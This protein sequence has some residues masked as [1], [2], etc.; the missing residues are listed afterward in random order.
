MKAGVS[1]FDFFDDT[2]PAPAANPTKQTSQ[3]VSGNFVFDGRT[4][5]PDVDFARLKN[6]TQRVLL[7]L[8]DYLK[9]GKDSLEPV[10]GAAYDSR[11]RDLR[12][13]RFG[14]FII[15]EER[16]PTTNGTMSRYWLDAS[17]VTDAKIRAILAWE[18]PDED[19]SEDTCV[20]GLRTSIRQ[21]IKMMGDEQLRSVLEYIG[22]IGE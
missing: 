17:S 1:I 7:R 21:A 18:I 10:G 9:H 15:H 11:I 12:K 4:Y 14:G 16:D 3:Y 6:N 20:K 13:A 8:L 2:A 22:N 19:S 5:D